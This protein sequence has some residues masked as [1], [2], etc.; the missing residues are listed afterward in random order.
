MDGFL[1]NVPRADGIHQ[2]EMKNKL[3]SLRQTVRL[4]LNEPKKRHIG[5]VY[6]A[7][8]IGPSLLQN[9]SSSYTVDWALVQCDQDAFES[10]GFAGNQMFVGGNITPKKFGEYMYPDVTDCRD[11]GHPEQ[12]MLP[13]SGWVET[14]A[15]LLNTKYRDAEGNYRMTVIKNGKAT[16]TTVGWF[17]GLKSYVRWYKIIN[18]QRM[19][20]SSMEMT[21]VSYGRPHGAFSKR[22]DSG[23]AILD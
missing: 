5:R 13:L 15:E 8:P 22:G 3:E 20:F 2:Q 11:F 17:N 18:N 21:F 6:A 10:P 14:E 19:E 9:P 23:S 1:Q 7:D 4:H 16:G 12:G